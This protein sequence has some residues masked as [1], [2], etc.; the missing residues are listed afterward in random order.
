MNFHEVAANALIQMKVQES[1]DAEWTRLSARVCVQRSENLHCLALVIFQ[2]HVQ[3]CQVP[4]SCSFLAR[5]R[6][7]LNLCHVCVM[8]VK[9]LVLQKLQE[10]NLRFKSSAEFDNMPTRSVFILVSSLI[11]IIVL[12]RR[13]RRRGRKTKKLDA[14]RKWDADRERTGRERGRERENTT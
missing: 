4:R 5:Y 12:T 14:Q 7:C 11:E 1:L 8:S 10:F 13:W 3:S 2:I 6:K 9:P